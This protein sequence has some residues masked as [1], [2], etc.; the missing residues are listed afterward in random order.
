MSGLSVYFTVLRS[1][2]PPHLIVF[3]FLVLFCAS[4]LVF[5]SSRF[6]IRILSV[7]SVL[8]FFCLFLRPSMSHYWDA[9]VTSKHQYEL[10]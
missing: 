3:C 5:P 7:P 10:N 1:S 8:F 4:C 6:L 2:H 9:W